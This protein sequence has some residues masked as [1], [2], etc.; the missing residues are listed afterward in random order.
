MQIKLNNCFFGCVPIKNN[1]KRISSETTQ[2]QKDF[3]T[4]VINTIFNN[5]IGKGANDGN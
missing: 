2:E 1:S 5:L 3:L 4:I